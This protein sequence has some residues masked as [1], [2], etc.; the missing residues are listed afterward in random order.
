MNHEKNR[1]R[2]HSDPSPVKTKTNGKT[3]QLCGH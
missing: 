1:R 2:R 3:L